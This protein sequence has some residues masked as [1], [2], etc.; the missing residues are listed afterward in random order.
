MKFGRKKTGIFGMLR[1]VCRE[2]AMSKVLFLDGINVILIEATKPS[3]T[4]NPEED[5]ESY[6]H[7]FT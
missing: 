2:E 4:A 6:G 5:N 1:E 3:L 7:K